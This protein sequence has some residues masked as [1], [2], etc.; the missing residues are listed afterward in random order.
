MRIGK[1][2][3][4]LFEI[5][6]FLFLNIWIKKKRLEFSLEIIQTFS[7]SFSGFDVRTCTSGKRFCG[8]GSNSI[9]FVLGCCCVK[10]DIFYYYTNRNN[11]KY[12]LIKFYPYLPFVIFMDTVT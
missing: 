2:F 12:L 5:E 11:Y 8:I 10:V 9:L 6:W 3:D 1:K 7:S 4:S